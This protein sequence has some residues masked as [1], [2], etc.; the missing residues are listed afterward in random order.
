MAVLGIHDNQLAY[1][2]I[3]YQAGAIVT[4]I[5]IYW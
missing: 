2:N 1:S 4:Y 5:S 3:D